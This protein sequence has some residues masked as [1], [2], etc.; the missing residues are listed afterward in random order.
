ME[1]QQLLHGHG[2]VNSTRSSLEDTQSDFSVMSDVEESDVQGQGVAEASPSQGVADVF[3][4]DFDTEYELP[5]LS[6]LTTA[7]LEGMWKYVP[8]CGAIE[9]PSTPDVIHFNTEQQPLA[10]PASSQLLHF[11]PQE[12]ERLWS[13]TM[14]KQREAFE[15]YQFGITQQCVDHEHSEFVERP[16]EFQFNLRWNS[17]VETEAESALPPS[18]SNASI[19]SFCPAPN[20]PVVSESSPAQS[21]YDSVQSDQSSVAQLSTR[22]PQSTFEPAHMPTLILDLAHVPSTVHVPSSTTRW[23]SHFSSVLDQPNE[24]ANVLSEGSTSSSSTPHVSSRPSSVH[25][26][27][28]HANILSEGSTAV[29]NNI[30]VPAPH[31]PSSTISRQV[32]AIY[33][34]RPL[35]PH[36]L[37]L[38]PRAPSFQ[39]RVTQ[40]DSTSTMC[41]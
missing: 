22:F 25:P 23:S 26:R 12:V 20:S 28:V 34:R 30:Y 36:R 9:S 21:A 16:S 5:D 3:Q 40:P 1:L 8:P 7:E 24:R 2:H 33:V 41:L 6:A 31:A 29:V 39:P 19:K 27:G 38:D 37:T 10:E 4:F 35:I 17:Q 11:T 18:C 15:N 32:S 14:Q 13:A